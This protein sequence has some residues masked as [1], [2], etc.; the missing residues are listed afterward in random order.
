ML[1]IA[2]SAS[3]PGSDPS[4]GTIV[5][6]DDAVLVVNWTTIVQTR[7][8]GGAYAEHAAGGPA[9]A[10]GGTRTRSRS[11]GSVKRMSG[12]VECGAP[13]NEEQPHVSFGGPKG[14][15]QQGELKP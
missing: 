11:I 5:R 14:S 4:C 10:G 9:Q 6:Y 7:P 2:D 15:E 1:S 12:V 3:P 13:V 8:V